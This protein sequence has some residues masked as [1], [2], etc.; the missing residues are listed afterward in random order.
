MWVSNLGTIVGLL[1]ILYS[2]VNSFLKLVP[3]SFQQFM[4]S[5]AIA[6]IVVFWYEIVRLIKAIRKKA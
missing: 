2:P 5:L 4:I 3:L 1:L 6:A